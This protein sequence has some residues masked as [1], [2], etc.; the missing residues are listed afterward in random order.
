MTVDLLRNSDEPSLFAVVGFT[1]TVWLAAIVF[2]QVGLCQYESG[3]L[4]TGNGLD[5]SPSLSSVGCGHRNSREREPD[6]DYGNELASDEHFLN[7]VQRYGTYD[8]TLHPTIG[9]CPAPALGPSR[10]GH[11][12]P[13]RCGYSPTPT[14]RLRLV[15]GG[16]AFFKA[17]FRVR[18]RGLSARVVKAA[19]DP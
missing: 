14:F 12:C 7:V 2:F 1:A 5:R 10:R 4:V 18:R 13:S 16:H 15:D 3:N 17:S 11:P 6:S 8:S 19:R 9:A